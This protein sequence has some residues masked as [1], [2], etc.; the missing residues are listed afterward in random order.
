MGFFRT[1]FAW[2]L[3]GGKRLAKDAHGFLKATLPP[4][5]ELNTR[6]V[7]DP[8]D[9]FSQAQA[10]FET[11]FLENHMTEGRRQSRMRELRIEALLFYGLAL[12]SLGLAVYYGTFLGWLGCSAVALLGA[13]RGWVAGFRYTQL[14]V[15][16]LM[17]G[18][19]YVRRPHTWGWVIMG[20]HKDKGEPLC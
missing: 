3:L 1:F 17:S 9:A 18:L 16:A 6:V 8:E 5:S 7:I 19:W 2:D 12:I 15:R 13:S 20:V 10:R 4:L 11:A 14:H